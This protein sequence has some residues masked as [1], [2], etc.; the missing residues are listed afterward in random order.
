MSILNK[1]IFFSLLLLLLLTPLPYGTV[2]TWSVTVWE[3]WIFA[4]TLL[5]GILSVVEGKITLSRNPLTLPLVVLLLFAL[6]QMLPLVSGDGRRT[7]SYDSAAT[8]QAALR[9]LAFILFFALFTTFVNTEERR[10][11]VVSTMIGLTFIIALIGLGQSYIGKALWQRGAFGPFVNRNH[12]AGFLEMGL[13]LAGG[14]LAGRGV[15][16]ERLAIYGCV[17]L[18]LL[19]GLIVS[20]SRGGILVFVA[21]A[22]FLFI[23]TRPERNTES[24]GIRPA[25]VRGAAALVLFSSLT[26]GVMILTGPED[27]LSNFSSLSLRTGTEVQVNSSQNMTDQYRRL[28]IWATTIQMIKDHPLAGIGLGAYPLA[29]TRYDQSSGVQRV[30]QSH[31]DYLQIVADAGIIGGLAALSFLALLFVRGLPGARAHIQPHRAIVTGSLTA[32]FGIV[33]HSLVDFNLQVTAS[34]QLFL[35]LAALAT[36]PRP[37]ERKH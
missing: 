31:N 15:R 3:L 23:V 24:R 7:L 22:I 12:F 4:T 2:E 8:L 30:E 35:A 25:L 27:L 34:A 18:V 36:M 5:W 11:L 6:V 20:A 32:C 9:L 21:E 14:L 29:Y 33:V 19:A 28:D 17:I 16:R 13:G 26:A 37:P 1:A 10:S